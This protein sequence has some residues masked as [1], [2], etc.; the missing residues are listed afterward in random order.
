[1]GKDACI[2]VRVAILLV[3]SDGPVKRA[4]QPEAVRLQTEA[5]PVPSDIERQVAAILTSCAK[6]FPTA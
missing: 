5:G 6:T 1:M 4:V 3:G 2:S